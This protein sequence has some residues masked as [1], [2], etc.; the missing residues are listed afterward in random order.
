VL[1]SSSYLKI[2]Q[3]TVADS[4]V[5][6][7]D[8]SQQAQFNMTFFSEI[9]IPDVSSVADFRIVD[10]QRDESLIVLGPKQLHVILFE[11]SDNKF[12][13]MLKTFPLADYNIT[14]ITSVHPHKLFRSLSTVTRSWHATR[15]SCTCFV[16]C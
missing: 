14:N 10:N 8:E 7:A 13:K 6:D 11:H 2:F 15:P 16:S 1:T 3:L 12:D 4:G 9:L 5:V